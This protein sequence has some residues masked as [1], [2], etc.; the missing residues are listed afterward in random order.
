VTVL[1]SSE[2]SIDSKIIVIIG[3]VVAVLLAVLLASFGTYIG[4]RHHWRKQK[5]VDPKQMNR[6]LEHTTSAG[7]RSY[8]STKKAIHELRGIGKFIFFHRL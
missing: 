8:F 3:V 2:S 4:V 5:P 6:D 7:N 1:E